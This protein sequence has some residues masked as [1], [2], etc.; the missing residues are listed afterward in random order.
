MAQSPHGQRKHSDFPASASERWMTCPGSV[1]L[2]RLAPPQVES[3]AAKE[4]TLGHECLEF[5]A[6]RV[7]S[8]GVRKEAL[9]RWPEDM[10]EHAMQS[11]VV[12]HALRP[13]PSAEL[14]M[15]KRVFLKSVS[16]R[17]FGTL[18]YAW[19]EMWGQLVVIDYKYGRYPVKVQYEDGRLN[20]QLMYYALGVA[21]KYNFD[22]DQV[23]LV[24]IQP[25]LRNEDEIVKACTT[26]IGEVKRFRERIKKAIAL[27]ETPNAPLKSGEHCRF[28]PAAADCPELSVKAMAK[29]DILFDLEDGIEA[30]PDTRGLTAQSLPKALEAA[31]LLEVWIEAVRERA[32]KLAKQGK[33]IEG[34][35][36]IPTRS[37]RVWSATARDIL[38]RELGRDAFERELRLLSPA[39]L[40]K[41]SSKAKALTHE[42]SVGVSTGEKLVRDSRVPSAVRPLHTL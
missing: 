27:A 40:E 32:F 23:K 13:S 18:D 42:L 21:E 22:F 37:N 7:N 16:K 26:T 4:G 15:E 17:A 14:L 41:L 31:D 34:Y 30:I 25:R 10:V 29:T 36:L 20:S 1:R 19:V 11:A 35:T 12:I 24:V 2:S 9:K 6:K 3:E 28:C 5:I 39:K 33:I 8:P 38:Q